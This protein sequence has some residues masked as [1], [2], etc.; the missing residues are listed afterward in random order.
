MAKRAKKKPPVGVVSTR[1]E[2]A[3]HFGV[4]ER[5][6]G[7]WLGGGCPGLPGKYDLKTIAA[8]AAASRSTHVKGQWEERYKREKAK[9]ARLDR[10]RK[11]GE[12]VDR[13]TSRTCWTILARRLRQAG[14]SLQ[15]LFGP[16]AAK[17]LNE[18]IEDC[19]REIDT[20]FPDN[21]SD[22]DSS[23]GPK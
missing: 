13:S 16:G 15:K 18:A 3:K 21:G 6:V 12:L 22:G 23:D 9:L 1:S 11:E 10:L 19:K 2:V 7:T 14:T 17:I 8:W 5:T 4:S 20:T